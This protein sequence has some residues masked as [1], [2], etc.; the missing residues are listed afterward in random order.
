MYVFPDVPAQG[1]P[2]RMRGKQ[3]LH[4]T[5]DVFKGITPAH[6]GKTHAY[7]PGE[8]SKEDHPR[9]CGENLLPF[10]CSS[11]LRGSPPRMRGK[12]S[13]M[14][15]YTA[16]LRIT[17][18]HA[19]KTTEKIGQKGGPKDHPRACGEN[20]GLNLPLSEQAGSPPRMRG[21]LSSRKRSSS[22]IG[23][24]PAHAGKTY[25][26]GICYLNPEDHPRACG[27][28]LNYQYNAENGRGSPPR[29][30]GKHRK[31]YR[32]PCVGRITPAHAGKTRP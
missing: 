22:A 13:K 26:G 5:E 30:R 14:S 6:A 18:A 29:M 31:R 8:D 32:A 7:A 3:A 24:T 17:P 1:S 19:G 10:F 12:L 15:I 21:K 25:R 23:I 9:A 16:T 2:P 28:N 11:R 27:E 4:L 20:V